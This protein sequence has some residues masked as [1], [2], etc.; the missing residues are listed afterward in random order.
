MAIGF[1]TKF[2]LD[3][4]A[5]SKRPKFWGPT[6]SMSEMEGS[7]PLPVDGMVA[8]SDGACGLTG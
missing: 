3:L 6:P 4:T 2:S 7:T 8:I 5:P 1:F